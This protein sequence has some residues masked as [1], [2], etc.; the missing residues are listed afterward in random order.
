MM[1]YSATEFQSQQLEDASLGVLQGFTT[2]QQAQ[3]ICQADR[4]QC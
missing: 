1:A 4:P 3:L 2:G